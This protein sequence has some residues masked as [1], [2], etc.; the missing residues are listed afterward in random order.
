METARDARRAGRPA[1][2]TEA[3]G[4]KDFALVW[5]GYDPYQVNRYIDYLTGQLDVAMAG[6]DDVAA[7]QQQLA[8]AHREIERLRAIL[9]HIPSSATV[10][11][12]ITE[13]IS[14]AEQQAAELRAQ[15]E[16]DAQRIREA[17][18]KEAEQ[19]RARAHGG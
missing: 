9:R 12:R 5:H 15:A 17:A 4:A 13:I 6:L 11:D 3:D 2:G 14:L 1:E 7:L 8:L 10:G 16:R 19:I 18:E